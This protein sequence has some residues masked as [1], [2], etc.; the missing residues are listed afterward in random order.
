[1]KKVFIILLLI[2]VVLFSS[3][4]I[5]A[6]PG[7]DNDPIVVLSYLEYRLKELVNYVD[8]NIISLNETTSQQAINI[9]NL[10]TKI[11]E[12]EQN[13]S[14]LSNKIENTTNQSGGS[15]FEVVELNT[16]QKLIAEAGTEIIIRS[17]EAFAI[18]NGVD[19][20]SDIT[21]AKDLKQGTILPLNHLVIVPRSDGRGVYVE[22]RV[23]LMIRGNYTIIEP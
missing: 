6:E 22:S 17:G 1:M 20:L 23:F 13:I 12:Q 5:S 7:D 16:G 19:G 3:L 4:T 11:K 9:E 21:D 15:V 14:N 10:N 2:A 18:D 8:T